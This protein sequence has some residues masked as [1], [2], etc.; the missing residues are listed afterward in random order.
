MTRHQYDTSS[1]SSCKG[2]I[3]EDDNIFSN[4]CAQSREC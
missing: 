3:D 1:S 2:G 4:F